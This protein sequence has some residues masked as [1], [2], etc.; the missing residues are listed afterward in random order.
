MDLDTSVGVAHFHIINY[1]SHFH[2][3]PAASH[4]HRVLGWLLMRTDDTALCAGEIFEILYPTVRAHFL[5]LFGEIKYALDMRH[6]DMVCLHYM[7]LMFEYQTPIIW[8]TIFNSYDCVG[9]KRI[10]TEQSRLFTKVWTSWAGFRGVTQKYNTNKGAPRMSTSRF[11]MANAIL[12]LTTCAKIILCNRGHK[13]RSKN[14]FLLLL[15]AHPMLFTAETSH[16]ILSLSPKSLP[17]KK[18]HT[19]QTHQ[20]HYWEWHGACA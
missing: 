8:K 11:N 15:L 6:S 5:L 7:C 14:F 16:V 10:L 4:T 13:W 19:K 18:T 20:K 2:F 3:C 1:D 9:L 17:G 12:Q